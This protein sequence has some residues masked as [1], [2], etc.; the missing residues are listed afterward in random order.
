MNPAYSVILFTTASGAGYGLLFLAGLVGFNHGRASSS[1]FAI[2]TIVIALA[3]ITIGLLSSTFHLGR[4]ERAW[5]AFSQWRSSWLSREGI[6]AV[7]TYPAALLFGGAWSGLIDTQRLIGP[8]GLITATLCAATV[9]CTGMIYASLKTIARWNTAWVPAIY[10]LFALATGVCILAAIA[11]PFGRWQIFQAILAIV[12]LAAVI[13]AKLIYWRRTDAAP[14][15]RT[16]GQATG[17]GENVRQWE[18]PHTNTNF[19]QKEMGFAVARKHATKLRMAVILFLAL[20]LFL[21]ACTFISP[22]FSF[23]VLPPLAFAAWIERWLFFAEA[24]HIVMLYYGAD[25]R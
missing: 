14:R 4:P 24:E 10:M 13:I 7:L 16:T 11:T 23:A 25:A 17:L 3:L 18:L 8:L 2:T 12:A 19:I 1:A 15:N 9:F 21:M 22:W 5:R 6:L 20:A